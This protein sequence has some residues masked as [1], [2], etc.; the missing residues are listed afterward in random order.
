[1]VSS[2]AMGQAFAEIRDI[3]G[4]PKVLV[5]NAGYLEGQDLP[6][7][8]EQL[9]HIPTGKFETALDITYR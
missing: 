6:A 4:V 8:K 9:E 3:A 7:D 2:D 5:Y 1:M